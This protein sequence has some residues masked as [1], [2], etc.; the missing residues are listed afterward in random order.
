[1]AALEDAILFATRAHSGQAGRDGRPYILHPLRMMAR[2][3]SELEQ[4]VALLHDVVEKTDTTLDDLR[5][6]GFMPEVVDAVDALT[7]REGESYQDLVERAAAS[8]LARAV[9]IADLEDHLDLR[10]VGEIGEKDVQRM[11]R[12]QRAWRRLAG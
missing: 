1:M 3:N 8:P 12:Q 10:H 9:K 6:A 2:F 4:V 7:Q 11:Q 5:R